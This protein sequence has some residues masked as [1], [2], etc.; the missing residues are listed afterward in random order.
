MSLKCSSASIV[1]FLLEWLPK[2]LGWHL[3][4]GLGD[5]V[6]SVLT[7]KSF[8]VYV[9]IEYFSKSFLQSTIRPYINFVKI[10]Y[11]NNCEFSRA[12]IGLELLSIR[13]QTMEKCLQFVKLLYLSDEHSSW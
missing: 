5:R 12:L 1:L 7:V 2:T 10:S 8:L 11:Y 9:V 13:V 4:H 6:R 3:E